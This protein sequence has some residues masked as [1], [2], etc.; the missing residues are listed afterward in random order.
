MQVFIIISLLKRAFCNLSTSLLSLRKYIIGIIEPTIWLIPV[1][2]AAPNTPSFNTYMN[3]KSKNIL[4]N[5]ASSETTSPSFGFSATTRKLWKAFCR[6]NAV[7]ITSSVLPYITQSSAILPLAPSTTAI[8]RINIIPITDSATPDTMQ[9][10]I[11]IEK[12]SLAFSFLPSPSVFDT[13]AL[14]PVPIINPTEPS[15]ITTGI[16]RLTAA[17]ASLPTKLDTNTPST[18][19]YIDVNII[20]IIV[21]NVNLI[22]LPYEKWSDNF[23]FTLILPDVL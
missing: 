16:I 22:S 9:R 8:G 15:I 6:N 3:R 11:S 13:M 19:P 21:G 12:Y 23:I 5:P 1:A 10:Y 18:T 2:S 20:I 17:N 7:S 4:V 14:P